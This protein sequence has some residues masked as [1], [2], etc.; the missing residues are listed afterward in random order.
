VPGETPT[1]DIIHY[2]R[3]VVHPLLNAAKCLHDLERRVR[4][5][6]VVV[7]HLHRAATIESGLDG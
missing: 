6:V 5:A 2:V 4:T 7:V 3:S 1:Y